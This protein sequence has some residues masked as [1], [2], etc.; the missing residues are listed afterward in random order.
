[1]QQQQQYYPTTVP[2]HGD[3]HHIY[4]HPG[5]Y[6]H[7][8]TAARM[9]WSPNVQGGQWAAAYDLS[10]G[11][12]GFVPSS[13]GGL[14]SPDP[15]QSAAATPHNIRDILGPGGQ[16]QQQTSDTLQSEI[17]KTP[18]SYQKS[19]SSAGAATGTVF[20]YP[21]QM[22]G[23]EMRSPTNNSAEIPAQFYIPA[24]QGKPFGKYSRSWLLICR[25]QAYDMKKTF[26]SCSLTCTCKHSTVQCA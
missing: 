25:R 2:R 12:Q 26:N 17:A 22:P 19:P 5:S 20:H 4:S 15:A 18:S 10:A 16:Q 9:Q 13:M 3:P 24:L 6:I 7:P 11:Y 21:P 1:M 14:H 23:G 8:A